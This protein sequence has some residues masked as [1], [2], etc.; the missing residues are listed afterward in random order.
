MLPSFS[1]LPMSPR[2]SCSTP[3]FCIQ[4][5]QTDSLVV[6]AVAAAGDDAAADAAADAVADGPASLC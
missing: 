2:A 6:V 1:W 3:S 5:R 4:C